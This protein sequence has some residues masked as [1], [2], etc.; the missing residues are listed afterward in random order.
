MGRHLRWDNLS[1][2]LYAEE[3]NFITIS[4]TCQ[5]TNRRHEI[6]DQKPADFQ[7]AL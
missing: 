6:L 4:A 2:I 7:L 3:L 1:S 5:T